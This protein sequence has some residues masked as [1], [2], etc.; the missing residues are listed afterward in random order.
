MHLVEVRVCHCVCV[1]MHDNLNL[2]HYIYFLLSSYVDWRKISGRILM[3]RLQVN[4]KVNS[5]R[6]QGHW[7]RL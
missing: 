2:S 3:S 1:R 7:V 5:R 6:V 4:V